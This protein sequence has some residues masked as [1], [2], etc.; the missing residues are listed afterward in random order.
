MRYLNFED[1]YDKYDNI[2]MTRED[3]I[4]EMRLHTDGDEL[5]WKAPAVPIE[6]AFDDLSRDPENKLVILTGTGNSFTKFEEPIRLGE[7]TGTFDAHEWGKAVLPRAKRLQM[8]HL[9]VPVPMIAAVNGPA[10]VHSEI[11]LLCDIVLASTNASFS[12]SSHFLHG[13]VPGDGVHIVWESLLGF[14]RGRYYMLT[15]KSLSAEEALNLGLVAEVL[16]QEELL[17]RARELAREILRRPELTVRLTREAL[18]APMRR[19]ML[20]NVGFGIMLEGLAATQH[21]PKTHAHSGYA[22][23]KDSE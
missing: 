21:W 12:D 23:W 3:G 7:T 1:Y 6:H 15:G 4:L 14:N 22:A 19:M 8:N 10:A 11:A 18:V 5:I 17:P 9:E 16:P 13:I 20:D 2:A